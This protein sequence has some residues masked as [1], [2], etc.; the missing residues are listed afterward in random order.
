MLSVTARKN[1]WQKTLTGL[2]ESATVMDVDRSRIFRIVGGILILSSLWAGYTLW[3]TTYVHRLERT[4]QGPFNSSKRGHIAYANLSTHGQHVVDKTIE[5]GKFVV[6]THDKTVA[7]FSYPTDYNS[8]GAGW[9]VIRRDG[10]NYV[11]ATNTNSPGLSGVLLTPLVFGIGLFG[12]LLY[13]L[14]GRFRE[15]FD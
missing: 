6:E 15:T 12:V 9:Y 8:L 10:R 13:L 4:E 7:A 14:G 11:I 2:S 3:N 1:G 5:R